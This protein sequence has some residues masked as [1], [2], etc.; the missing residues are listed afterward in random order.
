[1]TTR[2]GHWL[3]LCP[4]V[5]QLILDVVATDRN[6]L[7]YAT[8]SREW[9]FH[10]E[11]RRFSHLR[12]DDDK[13]LEFLDRNLVARQQQHVVYIWLNIELV[14]YNCRKKFLA[15]EAQNEV[16]KNTRIITAAIA[17]LYSMLSRWGP[18]K[19]GLTLELSMQSPSDYLDWFPNWYFGGRPDVSGGICMSPGVLKLPQEP[20]ERW[21]FSGWL[22]YIDKQVLYRVWDQPWDLMFAGTLPEVTAV[23]RFVIRRQSRRRLPPASLKRMLEALP[24]LESLVCCMVLLN[25]DLPRL[26]RISV[27]EDFNGDCMRHTRTA[28]LFKEAV[29]GRRLPARCESRGLARRFAERSAR[30]QFLEHLSVAFMIEASLFFSSL[31]E[32]HC[33]WPRLRSLS[34]TSKLLHRDAGGEELSSLLTGAAAAVKCM[35][36]LGRM[37]LWNAGEGEGCSFQYR[38]SQ[39]AIV[40][41]GVW[42]LELGAEVL[43]AWDEVVGGCV[44]VVKEILPGKDVP[45]THVEAMGLLDLPPGIVDDVSLF[46]MQEEAKSTQILPGPGMFSC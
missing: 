14:P 36:S 13:Q 12:L 26:T 27:F 34:L 35:P 2:A 20:D 21:K 43:R 22:K 7:K 46:Q 4:E 8:V 28:G 29:P 39:R 24:R 41:R 18:T 25:A 17:R 16:V 5:R 33:T 38:R 23:T 9:Q 31:A 6:C 40:W 44:Q 15:R 42:D 45:R 3:T 10:L 32:A 1:M 37:F 11:S 30:L 19:H